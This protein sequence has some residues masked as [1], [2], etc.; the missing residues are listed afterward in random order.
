ME[1]TQCGSTLPS[2]HPEKRS[3]ASAGGIRFSQQE[4]LTLNLGRPILVAF[5]AAEPALSAVEG[6][7]IRVGTAALGCPGVQSAPVLLSLHILSSRPAEQAS[8]EGSA[9]LTQEALTLNLGVPH[10]SRVLCGGACP[11]RSRRD[12][13][14]RGDSRPRLSRRAK[15]AS[16]SLPPHLVIPTSGASERGGIRFSH[17]RSTHSQSR[18]APF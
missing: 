1:K 13:D 12:L 9:F 5:C 8:A 16:S 2:C 10:S 15:R 17:A 6:I 4:A 11:E 14:S 3:K 18:G 7:W